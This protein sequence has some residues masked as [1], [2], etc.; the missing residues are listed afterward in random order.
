MRPHLA[1]TCRG[2]AIVAALT[3]AAPAHAQ[4]VV[5]SNPGYRAY[6]PRTR[7][8]YGPRMSFGEFGAR[9]NYSEAFG[10]PYGGLGS[11]NYGFGYGF[12]PGYPPGGSTIYSSA[13]N[14]PSPNPVNSGYYPP[15]A[16][17]GTGW[18]N[19]ASFAAPGL[20]DGTFVR[21][22]RPLTNRPAR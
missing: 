9:L 22:P 18:Q 16:A 4:S 14:V 10:S 8:T 2:L 6:Y 3:L 5:P 11:I 20:N 19:P 17:Y 21:T 7:G 1:C 12:G 15:F 13:Y